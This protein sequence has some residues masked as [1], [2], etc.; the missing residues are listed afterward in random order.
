MAM[1]LCIMNSN[2]TSYFNEVIHITSLTPRNIT[3]YHVETI[4]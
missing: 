3:Q 4:T 2:E 1:A